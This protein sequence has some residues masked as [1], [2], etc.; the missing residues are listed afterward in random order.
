MII[1]P[2]NGRLPLLTPEAVKRWEAKEALSHGRG[3]SD[4]YLDRSLGDR[5][6]DTLGFGRVGYWGLGDPA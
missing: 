3:E 4:S 2:P 1:D 6:I 5:C